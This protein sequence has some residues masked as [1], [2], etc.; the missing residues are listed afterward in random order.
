[1]ES[2]DLSKGFIAQLN[3]NGSFTFLLFVAGGKKSSFGSMPPNREKDESRYHH[4]IVI[5][6][7]PSVPSGCEI[8]GCVSYITLSIF[9]KSFVPLTFLP[10]K[11]KSFQ[12]LNVFTGENGSQICSH[13]KFPLAYFIS[14]PSAWNCWHFSA[15]PVNSFLDK[16]G[17]FYYFNFKP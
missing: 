10:S 15:F 12:R 9:L 4:D 13:I 14:P 3:R 11:R 7:I 1:M 8:R 17:T 16:L 6:G 2:T 5:H